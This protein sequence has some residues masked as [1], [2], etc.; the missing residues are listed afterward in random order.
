MDVSLLLKYAAVVLREAWQRKFSCLLGFALI[1]FMVLIVGILWNS[2]FVSS[3]T[4]FADNQNIL[5]PLLDDNAVHSD[6]ENQARV[7][8]DIIYSPRILTMVVDEVYGVD[9][10]E[11]AEELGAS[12]NRL[13]SKIQVK[14]IGSGY[15][16]ISYTGPTSEDAYK[17]INSVVDIFINT[18]TED[19]KSESREAFLFIDN[20]V[21]QYKDQLLLA[22]DKLKQFRAFNYDGRDGDVD[23]SIARLRGQIEE[24]KISLDEDNITIKTLEKQLLNESEFSSQ[25]FKTDVYSERLRHLEAQR[26]NLLLSFTE[27]YPDVVS[28]TYQIED[29][30]RS[31]R[32]QEDVE[33]NP[34]SAAED[35]DDSILNPLYQELRSRLSQAMTDVKTKEKRLQAFQKLLN[36]EYER[37]KRLAAR[38]AEEAELTRDYNVT[39]RIYEDMLE[40]KETARLSMTLNVEGQGVSY[41]VQEPALPPLNPVGLRFIHFVLLGPFFGVFGVLGLLVAYV[42]L[43]S[44]VRFSDDLQELPVETLAVVPHIKTPFTVRV[45]KFDLIICFVLGSLVMLGYF[46]LAYASKLG[47]I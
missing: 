12:I 2:K 34:D 31:M 42:V 36:N 29:I 19:Q 45:F 15:I 14:R 17:V 9:S 46:G 21:K 39:M 11:S 30:K 10:F 22:E 27:D 8:R 18:S 26:N 5:K 37:R 16:K 4:L 25:K 13:R 38:A 24:L 33:S 47:L 1:S 28:I 40:K 41:R 6:V 3:A 32:E 7:V 23:A 43:D 35:S 44:K 20:Q